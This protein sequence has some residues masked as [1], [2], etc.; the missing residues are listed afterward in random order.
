MAPTLVLLLLYLYSTLGT[1]NMILKVRTRL[2]GAVAL[3]VR[4][5]LRGTILNYAIFIGH[6]RGQ[7]IQEPIKTTSFR[8]VPR[9]TDPTVSA[10]AR[11]ARL[12]QVST[13]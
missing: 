13:V 8:I 12:M 6:Y 11:G 4:S 5:V 9:G 3:T 10:M 7:P 2:L 1:I